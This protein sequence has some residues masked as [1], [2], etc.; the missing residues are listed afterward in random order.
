[1]YFGSRG[2][3][4]T[5]YDCY[6]YYQIL[7]WG[8]F[9]SLA[10]SRVVFSGSDGIGRTL[11]DLA[12]MGFEGLAQ[13]AG[14]MDNTWDSDT[15]FYHFEVISVRCFSGPGKFGCTFDLRHVSVGQPACFCFCFYTLDTLSCGASKWG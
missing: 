14:W 8:G 12:R 7:F 13:V 3:D 15:I 4:V 6:I 9:H 5:R 11:L 2:D 1:M 10:R